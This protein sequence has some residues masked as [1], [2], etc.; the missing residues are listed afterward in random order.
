MDSLND[1]KS[2]LHWRTF[3]YWAIRAIDVRGIAS[4]FKSRNSSS[5]HAHIIHAIIMYGTN[6]T[7]ISVSYTKK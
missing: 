4:A 7:S 1:N 5:R 6:N 3:K 2:N